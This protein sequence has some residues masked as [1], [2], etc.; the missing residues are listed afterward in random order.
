MADTAWAISY[1]NSSM[2]SSI[3]NYNLPLAAD[4]RSGVV[5]GNTEA[6]Q[7][8]TGTYEASGGGGLLINPGMTGGF[9]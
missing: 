7:I 6:M 5:V 3:P 4:L 9:K 1:S 2:K 8:I